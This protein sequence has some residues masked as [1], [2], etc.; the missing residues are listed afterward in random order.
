MLT[1]LYV[2]FTFMFF[3]VSNVD[4]DCRPVSGL[5][6]VESS[7]VTVFGEYHGTKEVPEFFYDVVCNLYRETT[8]PI[9]IG[10]ELEVLLNAAFQQPHDSILL[11]EKFNEARESTP[12]IDGRANL[13][14][15]KMISKILDI[16]KNNRIKFIALAEENWDQNAVIPFL[17]A[18]QSLVRGAR[19]LV[20][21]GNMHA[22]KIN[23]GGYK[24]F[25]SNLIL[26]TEGTDLAVRSFD[27]LPG[28]GQAW[29]CLEECGPV[30]LL[31]LAISFDNTIGIEECEVNKCDYDGVY[32]IKNISIAD[33]LK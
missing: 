7:A 25:T 15:L 19:A 18:Y 21:V 24:T 14:T 17:D 12:I 13:D 11:K 5:S 31:P 32:M 6:F 8:D 10:L 9:L 22:R 27:L 28:G 3:L 20:L 29:V 4:A 1:K 30:T 23:S 2:A 26:A 33:G 16:D